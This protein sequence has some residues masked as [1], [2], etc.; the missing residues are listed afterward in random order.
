MAEY[1]I[2]HALTRMAKEMEWEGRERTQ[3]RDKET[4][5][6]EMSVCV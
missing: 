6:E 1:T 3:D 4:R 5:D 2:T